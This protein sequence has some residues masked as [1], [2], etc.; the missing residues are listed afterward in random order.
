MRI[1]ERL[2][3]SPRDL[4]KY[5]FQLSGGMA[6]RILLATAI[7]SPAELIKSLPVG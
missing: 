7:L 1:A 6:R 2:D 5:P 4:E 3:L